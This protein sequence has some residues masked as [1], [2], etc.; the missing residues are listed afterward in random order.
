MKINKDKL[1][2]LFVIHAY[3]PAH[4]AGAEWY[5]KNF[6]DY[7]HANNHEVKVLCCFNEIVDGIEVI[8][9]TQKNFHELVNWCDVIITHLGEANHCFNIKIRP[10]I[11]ISHNS[12]R[13]PIDYGTN[14][15]VIYN[16]YANQRLLQYKAY[17]CVLR[18]PVFF[19][20]F[21]QVRNS[22]E[23]KYVTLINLNK[24]KGGDVLIQIASKM[25]DVQFLGIEGSYDSQIKQSLAN[26][27]YVRNTSKIEEY[28]S[29]TKILL[30]PSGSESW[31]MAAVEAM[32]C[33]IP[34]LANTVP[35]SAGSL[36]GMKEALGD[37]AIW[38]DRN[39]IND[40]VSV[41]YKLLNNEQEYGK[42]SRKVLEQGSRLSEFTRSDLFSANVFIQRV[43]ERF[44]EEGNKHEDNA[45][46]EK[47]FYKK[48]VLTKN[49]SFAGERPHRAGEIV[50]VDSVRYDFLI[51]SNA[52]I[53]VDE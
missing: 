13:Y 53:D 10:V 19:E 22:K 21:E 8:Q 47:I 51:K 20:R 4:N 28:L 46:D 49:V 11:F 26:V 52:C 23:K 14:L 24:N 50:V 44:Y 9:K 40:W 25:Q 48:V 32:M 37:A 38:L 36:D 29:K 41:I 34:V 16:S 39:K 42:W 31:G 15:F 1:K 18:P 2:I 35:F 30:M 12:H 17:N 5:A 45:K 3:P 6:A 33:G 7:L 43:V 27:E